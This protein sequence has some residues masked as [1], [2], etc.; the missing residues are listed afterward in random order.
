MLSRAGMAILFS[1]LATAMVSCGGGG[2]SVNTG[3]P[4]RI[5]THKVIPG[6][7][8]TSISEDF[9]GSGARAEALA[10]FNGVAGASPPFPGKGIRIPLYP[11]DLDMLDS[12]LDAAT[13]YNEG[14]DLAVGGDYAGAVEKFRKALGEDPDLH[15][16][17]F[18][19]AV[20]Y[21]KL[22]LHGNAETVLD[23]L[24]MKEPDNAEYYFALGN[25]RF[26]QDHYSDAARAFR[27]ALDID[28]GHLPSLYS[29]AVSCEK[30]GEE[31]S[32][33]DTWRRYLELDPDSEWADVA[34]A[35]LEE[36]ENRR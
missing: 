14:L 9:Y 30:M 2:K 31:S 32:A 23:D 28:P 35:R 8:W 33:E 13:I 16:A 36:L 22:G 18:N 34:R 3:E 26:H 7:S 15:E 25:S 20:T 11:E 6:E 29:F 5:V 17:S 12:R 27:S 24:V 4:S 10:L 1:I 21:Q 19:L